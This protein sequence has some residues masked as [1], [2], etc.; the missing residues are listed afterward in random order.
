MLHCFINSLGFS[1]YLSQEEF[2]M[3]GS[4]LEFPYQD[5]DPAKTYFYR[6]EF[7]RTT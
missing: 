4:P 3:L 7:N 6:P 5:G 1:I 2:D